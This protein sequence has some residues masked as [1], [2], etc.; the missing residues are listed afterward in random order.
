MWRVV[1]ACRNQVRLTRHPLTHM[2]VATG[3][4]MGAVFAFAAA[5]GADADL[6]A[7]VLPEVE[8]IVVAS[9]NTLPAESGPQET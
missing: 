8:T 1:E 5:S 4:D 2:P 3:L 7:A 6:L 9:I